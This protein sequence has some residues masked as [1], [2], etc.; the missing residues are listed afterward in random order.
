M[1]VKRVDKRQKA[2]A[3]TVEAH[4]DSAADVA[5]PRLDPGLYQVEVKAAR[6]TTQSPGA[7]HGVFEVVER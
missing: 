6:T 3:T 7:V 2:I 4:A 1:Q 5:L